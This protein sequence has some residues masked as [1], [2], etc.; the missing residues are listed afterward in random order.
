MLLWGRLATS[1]RQGASPSHLVPDF[2]SS[3]Y[4]HWC[5]A[6]KTELAIPTASTPPATYIPKQ[7]TFAQLDLCDLRG[8]VST[9]MWEWM[10]GGAKLQKWERWMAA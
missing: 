2:L 5:Q 8:I 1:G 9:K 3:S 6:K 4:L 7:A 10:I